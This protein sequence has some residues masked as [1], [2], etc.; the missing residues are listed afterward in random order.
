[1]L[2]VVRRLDGSDRSRPEPTGAGRLGRARP[3]R[4]AHPDRDV[5]RHLSTIGAEPDA[6]HDADAYDMTADEE[7]AE[8]HDPQPTGRPSSSR[9]AA[10]RP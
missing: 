6:E 5:P 4:P 8:V 10:R 7:T 3:P 2:D 9:E 1:M